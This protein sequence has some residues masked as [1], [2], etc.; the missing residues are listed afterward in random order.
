[1]VCII[2]NAYMIN[3]SYRLQYFL[4]T[5]LNTECI[6]LVASIYWFTCHSLV[7]MCG[8]LYNSNNYSDQEKNKHS[9]DIGIWRELVETSRNRSQ[10]PVYDEMIPESMHP[11]TVVAK[12]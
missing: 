1:M 8:S 10:S 5:F 12:Y 6:G 4:H 9:G 7:S 11:S 3:L 2:I